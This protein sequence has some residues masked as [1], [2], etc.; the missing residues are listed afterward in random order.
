MTASGG[1]TPVLLLAF[2]RPD[3]LQTVVE[4]LAGTE[5][6]LVLASVDGPR[7]DHPDD[8]ERCARVRAVAESVPWASEVR[9]KAEEANLGCGP[10][11]SSA[12]SWALDQVPEVIVIEDDCLPDP[13]FLPFCDELLDRYRD[14][15][16]VM[17]IGGT[18]WGADERRFAGRSYAFTSFAPVWGWATW[19]RA[20]ALYDYELES[21][22]RLKESGMDAGMEVSPRFRRLLERDWHLV[23]EGR[24]TWDHQWQYTV[25]RHHGLSV[26]PASNLVVN[27]GHRGD[28]TQHTAPD[29]VFAA[30]RRE[31]APTP[32][33]HPP[34]VARNA[35]VEA[36]FERIYWQKL[37]WPGH[38]YRRLV[39]SHRMRKI[40]RRLIPRP[41]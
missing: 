15:Q 5:P 20:W 25:I 4:G 12:I 17:Q 40:V 26:I 11:V 7:P 24:G 3:L 18:N 27:I 36:V 16:R 39:R 29:R 32:L 21:W 34:E 28:A 41:T 33:R 37:G 38:L 10:A 30:L 6:R 35:A 1:P 23:R 14:D 8:R 2:N 13:S 22:P 9:L 19:R 31:S